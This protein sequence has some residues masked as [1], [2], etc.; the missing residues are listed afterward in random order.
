MNTKGYSEI[1]NPGENGPSPAP[2]GSGINPYPSQAYINQPMPQVVV[3]P[4]MFPGIANYTFVLDPMEEL[5]LC[6]RVE[7]RQQ[8]QFFEQIS[9]CE[10]PNR[11]FV[12][13]QYPQGG[14]KMLFKCKEQSGCFQRQCC[15]ASCREFTMDV[16]HISNAGCLNEGFQNSLVHV[17]KPF[18]CT[19]FCLQRPEMIVN[20][21]KG[22]ELLGKIKQP[23][24]CCDPVF[25]IYDNAGAPKLFIHADCCQCGLC[26]ANNFCG[27]M[28]QAIFH[29]YADASMTQSIGSI[30]KKRATF[31]EM[32]TSADSYQINF[33][34]NAQPNEKLLLIITGLM[35]DYQYFEEKAENNDNNNRRHY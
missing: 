22:G 27:K 32:V 3:P 20:Y 18:K 34:S 13:T 7:I 17:N 5:A 4:I 12:F 25:T 8:P 2:G 24:S 9:G 15:S 33:P 10:S 16:K 35:I 11:Y 29:I 23:F 6:P 14:N 30:V 28:S 26:C 1:P 21:T 31:S 19:C